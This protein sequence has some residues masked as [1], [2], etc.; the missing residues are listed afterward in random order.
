[1]TYSGLIITEQ[2]TM[3]GALVVVCYINV[4]LIAA[5]K[6]CIRNFNYLAGNDGGELDNFLASP[7]LA[8]CTST[9]VSSKFKTSM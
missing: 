3:K 2:I 5:V 9:V 1:L 4:V 6:G 7:K 8:C